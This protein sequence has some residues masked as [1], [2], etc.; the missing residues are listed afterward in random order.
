MTDTCCIVPLLDEHVEGFCHAVAEVARERKFLAT[1]EGFPL[2]AS[3]QFVEHNRAKGMPN[4]AAVCDGRVVGWCDICRYDKAVMMHTGVV[5]I[6]ILKAFRGRGIGKQ[7]LE[8][9]IEAAKQAGLTRI[10]LVV[11]ED[12]S[13]A[14]ALYQKLGFE[15]EGLQRNAALVDGVYYNHIAM[16][17]LCT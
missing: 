2:E 11:R 8:K 6:R 13:S 1:F 15:R 9:A 3:R 16:A 14:I 10:E 4:L 12:N 7:L 5:G 17:L